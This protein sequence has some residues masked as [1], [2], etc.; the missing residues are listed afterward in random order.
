MIIYHGGVVTTSHVLL[1][2]TGILIII[3]TLCSTTVV[4]KS[5]ISNLFCRSFVGSD[6]EKRK[7]FYI[8]AEV[9]RLPH[10]SL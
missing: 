7:V 5:L 4:F 2:I 10:L 9:I 3:I 6:K 1:T 8:I